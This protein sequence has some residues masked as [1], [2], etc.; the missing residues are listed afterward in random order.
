MALL[1]T[2][3]ER[4]ESSSL[5]ETEILT[6]ERKSESSR[7]TALGWTRRALSLRENSASKVMAEFIGHT[8]RIHEA[9]PDVTPGQ[10]LDDI[11][12]LHRRFGESVGRAITNSLTLLD[13]QGER[14][15]LPP[16]SL[17]RKLVGTSGV[18]QTQA[19]AFAAQSLHQVDTETRSAIHG[20]L[21]VAYTSAQ[22]GPFF[23]VVEIADFSGRQATLLGELK[24]IHDSDHKTGKRLQSY[25]CAKA[26]ELADTLE[27]SEEDVRK[28]IQ[29]IRKS[30]EECWRA[31]PGHKTSVPAL[32]QN[33][34]RKGYRLEPSAVSVE[35]N[36]T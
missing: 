5:Y 26:S 10:I 33:R 2:G 24:R 3:N 14:A 30:W 25:R 34:P 35:R 19:T 6:G 31:I 7:A 4:F 23:S 12:D 27:S 11:I 20:T 1:A 32:V 18:L 8:D 21:E 16:T 22:W 15:T 9:I 28:L 17:L 29:R 36:A 13:E